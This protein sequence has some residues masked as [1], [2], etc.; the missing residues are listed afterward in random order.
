MA[1]S[2]SSPPTTATIPTW[3]GTD[4]T[5]EQAPVIAYMKGMAPGSIGARS[6]FADTGQTIARHI[7]I[8]PLAK[9]ESWL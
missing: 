1:I 8:A 4:H 7:G 6:S 9:G 2:S 5:R 3:K